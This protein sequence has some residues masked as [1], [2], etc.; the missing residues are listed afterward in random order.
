[1]ETILLA[2]SKRNAEI[3]A[4]ALLAQD[5]IPAV[6]YGKGEETTSLQMDYQSFRKIFRDGGG[7]TIVTLEL[8]G[9]KIPVLIHDVSYHPVT[10]RILHVDFIMVKMGEVITTEIP[11][12]FVGMSLAVKDLSGTLVTYMNEIEVKCLPKDLV[13]HIE[14]DI[15]VLE[16]FTSQITVA[17]LKVPSTLE[18][19]E[20]GEE[21]VASVAPPRAEE[22]SDSSEAEVEGEA[23]TADSEEKSE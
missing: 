23:V 21:L 4:K 22:E 5:I 2:V 10:D 17:D 14:V 11:L 6:C 7:N 3:K 15:S 1:M 16:D 12:E 9:K 13:Q 8:D 20:D 18:V 19:L